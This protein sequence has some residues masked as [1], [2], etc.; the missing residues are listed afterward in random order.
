MNTER[1]VVIVKPEGKRVGMTEKVIER[2]NALGLLILARNSVLFTSEDIKTIYAD[3]IGA[4][5]FESGKLLRQMTCGLVDILILE[6]K[7]AISLVRSEQFVGQTHLCTGLRG[8]IR[9][10]FYSYPNFW[11]EIR[12]TT[13]DDPKGYEYRYNG[14][15]ASATPEEA[16]RELLCL[17]GKVNKP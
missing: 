15:H 6:G 8:W 9:Q 10:N 4:E 7:Q 12:L 5:S 11:E 1:T 2:C 14:V 3:R 13:G 16:A 17:E